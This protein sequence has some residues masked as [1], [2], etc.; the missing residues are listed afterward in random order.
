MILLHLHSRQRDEWL[1]A[2]ALVK[3]VS[4]Q[5]LLEAWVVEKFRT[6]WVK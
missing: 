6:A 2:P 5:M 4:Q 3:R 1:Q